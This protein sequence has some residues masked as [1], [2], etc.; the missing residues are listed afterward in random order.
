MRF[1]ASIITPSPQLTSTCFNPDCQNVELSA[2]AIFIF[3][4]LTYLV[5]FSRF[6]TCIVGFVLSTVSVLLTI[7]D[8]LYEFVMFI[9]MRYI[10][11]FGRSM[12]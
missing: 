5:L 12:V 3:S 6:R 4:P 1:V 11:S 8:W 2:Y 7:A 10:P 9:S